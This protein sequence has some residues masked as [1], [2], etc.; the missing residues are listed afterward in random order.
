MKDSQRWRKT[1]IANR[2]L[3][4]SS[5]FMALATGFLATAAII[6]YLTL[7]GQL[8]T[9]QAQQ[10]TMQ[11]QAGAAKRSADIAADLC[12]KTHR[13]PK[14]SRQRRTNLW[15]WDQRIVSRHLQT[16]RSHLD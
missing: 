10:A 5:C 13:A 1:T 8:R 2:V 15:I 16:P 4:I 14:D 7:R 12:R 6:Q 11:E 3:V 9:M